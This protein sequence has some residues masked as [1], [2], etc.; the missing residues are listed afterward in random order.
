MKK[1]KFMLLIAFMLMSM[2]SVSSLVP[3]T[4]ANPQHPIH[5]KHN[6]YFKLD[7]GFLV[8]DTAVMIGMQPQALVAQLK[9]GKTLLQIV[10][11]KGITEQQYIHRLTTL[12][13]GHLNQAVVNKSITHEQAEQLKA[14]L[15]SVLSRAIHHKWQQA[16]PKPQFS[17]NSI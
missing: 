1:T 2:A 4:F 3:T 9:Q 15:P 11:S 12:A 10:Q 6:S 7:G 17:N 16:V 8:R 13:H 14:K 5:P